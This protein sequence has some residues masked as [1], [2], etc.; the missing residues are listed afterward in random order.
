MSINK[1][2]K[3]LRAVKLAAGFTLVM[4]L[5]LTLINTLL[6]WSANYLFCFPSGTVAPD[7]LF[8]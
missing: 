5:W 3:D 2:L 1:N 7:M 8:W 4:I 6:L